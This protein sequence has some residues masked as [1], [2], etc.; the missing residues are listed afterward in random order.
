MRVLILCTGNSCRSQMAEGWLKS[1]HPGWE[2][3]SAGTAPANEVH[4]LAVEVMREAGIDLSNNYPK[5][6]NL[7]LDQ[8]FDYV[9]TVC[10]DARENCPVFPGETKYRLH[11][12]FEDP[13]SYQGSREEKIKFFRTIR[14]QIKTFLTKKF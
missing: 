10:D 7:F 5:H 11:H 14:D 1:M 9:I 8:S 12:S 2:I 4:P 3:Y 6:V 13:A